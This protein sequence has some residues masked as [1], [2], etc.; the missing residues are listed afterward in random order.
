MKEATS[1]LNMSLV[2][3]IAIGVMA[4][5]FYTILWPQ[6][7]SNYD[8]NTKC[9]KAI[10]RSSTYNPNTGKVLCDLYDDNRNIVEKDMECVF[11]G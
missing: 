5:F 11:K 7:K 6:V 3:I 10:C 2:T 4:A 1:G 9:D 8:R